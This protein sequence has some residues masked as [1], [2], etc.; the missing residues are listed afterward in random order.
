MYK[1]GLKLA[2]DEL[3]KGGKV[4]QKRIS[5]VLDS[6]ASRIFACFSALGDLHG[7]GDKMLVLEMLRLAFGLDPERDRKRI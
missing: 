5:D 2:E 4:F 3:E 6:P 1:R 7:V